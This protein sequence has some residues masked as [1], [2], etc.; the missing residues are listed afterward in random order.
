MSTPTYLVALFGGPRDGEWLQISDLLRSVDLIGAP[1]VVD[2]S[3][4]THAVTNR[5]R[6]VIDET[7]WTSGVDGVARARFNYRP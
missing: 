6:Y 2:A 4:P 1:S 7:G 5:V 3:H